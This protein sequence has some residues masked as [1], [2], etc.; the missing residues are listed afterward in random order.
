MEVCVRYLALFFLFFW[1]VGVRAETYLFGVQPCWDPEKSLIMFQEL[2]DYLAAHLKVR[3][4]LVVYDNAE[5]FHHDLARI[6]FALQDAYSTYIHRY[7]ERYEPVAI[8]VTKEGEASE[9]GAI[10]VRKESSVKTIQDLKGK[11]F[12]FGS[13]HNTPKFFS[14]WILLKRNGLD[15]LKDF[16]EIG[17]GGDCLYNAMAVLVGDYEAGAVCADF[18]KEKEHQK[19]SRHLRVLAYTD[20][21]PGWMFTLAPR[22]GPEI[23]KE[24]TAIILRLAPGSKEAQRVLKH[25]PW[26]GFTKP[27]GDELQEIDRLVH[28]YQIPETL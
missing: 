26:L 16:R 6:H 17:L 5:Q 15:P 18:L 7:P 25:T 24:I 4:K 19:I 27:K 28:E 13:L 2:A 23:R 12:I 21:A 3:I 14:T 11:S 9:I 8:A 10:V 22:L 1:A 20:P